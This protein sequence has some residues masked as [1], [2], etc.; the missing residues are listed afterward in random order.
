MKVYISADIEGITGI[1]HWNETTLNNPEYR[2][3][4]DQMTK[5]VKAAVEA[6]HLSGVDEIVIRDAHDSARNISFGDLPDYVKFIKGWSGA[7]NDMMALLDET[8]DACLF[9]GYHSPS[10]SGGNPLSHTLSTDLHHIRI[11]GKIVSEFLLNTYYAQIHQV[12]VIFVSGDEMLTKSIEKENSEIQTYAAFSG[13]GGAVFSNH[14]D[15]SIAEIKT[16]VTQAISKL[17][18][19]KKQFFINMPR[20]FEVEVCYRNHKKA[21]SGSFYPNA[22]L[23]SY[24][25]ILY[26]T[27]KY[28]EVARFLHFVL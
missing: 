9:I 23:F 12:P 11:N 19:D 20:F 5:E 4:R 2:F 3:F 27:D 13:I 22:S 28:Y 1:N 25:K 8:F 26:K 21:Y 16:K 15:K 18:E 6:L 10:R 14:P 7:P 17:K 24:D